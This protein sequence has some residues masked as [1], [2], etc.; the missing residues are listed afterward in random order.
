MLHD[1]IEAYKAH[2]DNTKKISYPTPASYKAEFPFLREVDSLALA[3]AQ[4]HL[5][6]AYRNF[7]HDKS[8]G[9]LTLK[10]RN[11]TTRVIQ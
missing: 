10:V 6:L 2:K 8:S 3:N 7:F 5:N 11:L 9:F 1:R 4:L